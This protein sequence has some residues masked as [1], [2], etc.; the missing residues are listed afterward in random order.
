LSS[1]AGF[2]EYSH[3]VLTTYQYSL[4]FTIQYTILNNI[5]NISHNI[6]SKKRLP[7]TL[8]FSRLP[9]GGRGGLLTRPRTKPINIKQNWT[10]ARR[11][12]TQD[13]R[14]ENSSHGKDTHH[15]RCGRWG[16][17]PAAQQ[18]RSGSPLFSLL[19]HPP[20]TLLH[21]TLLL[22][23][24]V[25]QINNELSDTHPPASAPPYGTYGTSYFLK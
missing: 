13:T 24:L 20:S 19:Y 6:Y 15:H 18:K 2:A 4:Y 25:L 5:D 7:P 9:E 17:Q 22:F 8:K 3:P 14:P 21:T 11:L 23:C 1:L 12:A 16:E 10:A